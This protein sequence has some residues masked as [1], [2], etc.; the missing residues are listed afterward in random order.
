MSEGENDDESDKK[1]SASVDM[2]TN[3]VSQESSMANTATM[4]SSAEMDATDNPRNFLVNFP[5]KLHY[6]LNET[7][8]EGLGHIVSWMPH[9]RCFGVHKPKDFVLSILPQ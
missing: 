6:M 1:P 4:T 8:K 5:L 9:G 7:E 2:I 3:E